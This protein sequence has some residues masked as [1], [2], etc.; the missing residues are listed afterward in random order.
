MLYRYSSQALQGADLLSGLTDALVV[1]P[2]F[3]GD[4]GLHADVFHNKTDENQARIQKWFATT[5]VFT[6]HIEPI[7]RVAAD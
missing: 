1:M 6:D 5:G 3:F 2:N 4:D 7:Q